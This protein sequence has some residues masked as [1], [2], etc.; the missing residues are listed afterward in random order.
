MFHTYQR[1][2]ET[3]YR[4]AIIAFLLLSVDEEMGIEGLKKFSDFMGLVETEA[5]G[6]G[7]ETDDR[8]A[9]LRAERDKIIHEG[10]AFL[11]NHDGDDVRYD[12]VT[13]ALDHVMEKRIIPIPW[14][15]RLFN[16]LC[17]L[18]TAA[19]YRGATTY[20][21]LEGSACR[22]F[23]YLKLV[24]FDCD[25]GGNKKRF[26]KYLAK[27][28]GIDKSVLPTLETFAKSL[29]EINLRRVEIR[30]SDM[31]HCEAVTILADLD[32]REKTI[33]KELNRL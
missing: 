24:V 14:W 30:D 9:K 3:G 28:W 33:W 4:Y 32:V 23:G 22:L 12:C 13:E 29:D 16:P 27:K 26:L 10:N 1:P 31:P 8:F 19:M 17:G 7:N 25:Y 15:R 21:K 11:E 20:R 18:G 2:M 5:D 6:N